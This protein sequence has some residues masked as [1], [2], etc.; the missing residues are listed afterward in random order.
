MREALLR[1]KL[2]L[3]PPCSLPKPS[4]YAVL[5]TTDSRRSAWDALPAVTQPRISVC[6]KRQMT[7]H[8][9][10]C[11]D[12]RACLTCCTRMSLIPTCTPHMNQATTKKSAG[13][14]I[15]PRLAAI[16]LLNSLIKLCSPPVKSFPCTART[17]TL[18]EICGRRCGNA[19]RKMS[20]VM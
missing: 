4:A 7:E 17:C 18:H 16:Q 20:M 15:K 1:L 9:R 3:P 2:L 5:S 10:A 19:T 12:D 6:D 13:G 11:V 14:R 8:P